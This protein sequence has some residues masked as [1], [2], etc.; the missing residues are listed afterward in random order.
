[1]TPEQQL[2]RMRGIARD[3]LPHWNMTG[4]KLDLLK[5]RE[6]AVFRVS[7][8]NEH[9]ALRVHRPGYHSDDALR[10]ELQWMDALAAAGIDVPR[11]VPTADGEPFAVEPAPDMT[12][13]VQVDLF[14]WIEGRQLGSVESGLAPDPGSVDRVYTRLGALAAALHNQSESWAPPGSFVRHAWDEDGLAGERP[15]WGTFLDLPCLTSDQRKLLSAARDRVYRELGQLP[16]D[17]SGYSM[18]HADFSPENLLVQGER[19]RLIDFDDAGFGW[20]LF[21][22][23]TPLFFVMD[24]P[25]FEEARNAVISGYRQKRRLDERQLAHLPLFFLARAFTYLSWVRTR[26]ETSTARELTPMMVAASCR[27]AEDYLRGR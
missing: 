26:P 16:K 7:T 18:I 17:P 4:A 24:E 27:L 19:V 9:F 23:V 1:M 8:E 25:Y 11:V 10:S 13:P 22:L 15:F 12:A 3:A 2:H 6:N 20:H 5:H 21:E 14:E